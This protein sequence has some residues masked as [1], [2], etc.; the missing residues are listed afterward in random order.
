MCI[1]THTQVL[2][3]MRSFRSP[4]F[5][6]MEDSELEHLAQ[7]CRIFTV[8]PHVPTATLY[9]QEQGSYTGWGP[10]GASGFLLLE[11]EIS[12]CVAIDDVENSVEREVMRMTET[13]DSV[14]DYTLCTG[15]SRT[16]SAYAHGGS[17][18]CLVSSEAWDATVHRSGEVA[19]ELAAIEDQ[20]RR[21]GGKVTVEVKVIS[22]KV[23]HSLK[24][25]R[26]NLFKMLTDA[27]L[28]YIASVADV[29]ENVV[30]QTLVN[31]GETVESIIVVV[32]GTLKVLMAFS[33][34][35]EPREVA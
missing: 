1:H 31:Q 13:G 2:E 7:Y 28:E 26:S 24:L 23:T 22:M 12:V 4:L 15:H 32:R 30:G 33:K 17:T 11:G 8:S 20:Y 29:H 25:R 34:D 6:A 21:G 27:E 10:F 19:A 5:L 16:H 18:L 9:R 14:G 3:A 35:E